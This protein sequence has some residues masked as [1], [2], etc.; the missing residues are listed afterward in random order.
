MTPLPSFLINKNYGNKEIWIDKDVL[1][2]YYLQ[3]P[4]GYEGRML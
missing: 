1:A 3:N 4:F 2:G